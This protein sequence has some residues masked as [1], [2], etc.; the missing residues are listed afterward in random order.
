MTPQ[1]SIFVAFLIER[2]VCLPGVGPLLAAGAR[3][4]MGECPQWVFYLRSGASSLLVDQMIAIVHLF[5]ITR[6]E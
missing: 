5:K 1:F 3:F 2:A 6:L 4:E